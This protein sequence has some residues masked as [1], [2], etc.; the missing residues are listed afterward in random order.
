MAGLEVLGWTAER[1]A[2][3]GPF[4]ARALVPARVAVERRRTYRVLA[5]RGEYEGA[6]AGKL[7][8]RAERRVELPAVGDWVAFATPAHGGVGSIEAVLPRTSVFTRKAAGRGH[9]EQI[10][11]A[12]VDVV[13]LLT[14]LNA[15]FNPRRLERYLTLAWESGATPV[16]VL[17]KADRCDDVD[18]YRSA[19]ARVA[20]G[21]DVLVTSAKT[22]LG[23]EDVRA[24]LDTHRTGALLGSSGVGKSTFVNALLGEER[25]RTADIREAGARGRHTTTWRELVLLPGGGILIDT[26]GMR[27]LQLTDAGHGL[28]AAFDDIEELAASCAFSDCRHLEEPGCAVTAAVADRRLDPARYESYHKL[29]REL[30]V[31]A[32]WEHKRDEAALRRRA[33]AADRAFKKRLKDKRGQPRS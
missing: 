18:G 31:R 33:A 24:R 15:E 28:L 17:T 16:V 7:R 9:H 10:V 3:F 2:G 5:A 13:F 20:F 4:A 21:V 32:A 29:A 1:E 26:P 19:V 27:E 11:A 30:L 25:L 8:H 23:V 12:N 22:G 14:S 6:L